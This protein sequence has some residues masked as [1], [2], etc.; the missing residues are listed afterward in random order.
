MMISHGV[1]ISRAGAGEEIV[2]GLSLG[3]LFFLLFLIFLIFS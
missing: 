3:H 2:P 1:E